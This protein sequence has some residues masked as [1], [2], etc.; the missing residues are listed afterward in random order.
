MPAWLKGSVMAQRSDAGI[1]DIIVR[2]AYAFREHVGGDPVNAWI[3]GFQVGIGLGIEDQE[4]AKRINEVLSRV[5]AEWADV[6]LEA[7]ER[8]VHAVSD[9]MH[10]QITRPA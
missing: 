7:V 1:I 10:D 2:T 8:E 5:R 4:T 6:P 3:A 9:W